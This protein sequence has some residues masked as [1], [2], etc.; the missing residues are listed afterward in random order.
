MVIRE[1][2]AGVDYD[3]FKEFCIK[4]DLEVNG[5]LSNESNIL[6]VAHR[7]TA[8]T[9]TVY[10]AVE[11]G[12]ILGGI[13]M[14][15]LDDIIID[16]SIVLKSHWDKDIFGKLLSFAKKFTDKKIYVTLPKRIKNKQLKRISYLYEVI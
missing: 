16:H 2:D 10:I 3:D 6:E 14:L 5:D 11:D 1:L 8:G 7:Y 9:G 4:A 15:E 12:E 13:S